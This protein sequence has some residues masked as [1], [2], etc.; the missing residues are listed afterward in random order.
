MKPPFTCVNVEAAD[1]RRLIVILNQLGI[2]AR[3][4]RL[5]A[6]HQLVRQTP[7]AVLAGVLGVSPDTAT[8]H[9]LLAGAGWATFPSQVCWPVIR[10]L[11]SAG[12]VSVGLRTL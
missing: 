8:R 10:G 2:P 9:A 11:A 7:L 3:A 12:Q 5:A 6:W 4:S 1:Y